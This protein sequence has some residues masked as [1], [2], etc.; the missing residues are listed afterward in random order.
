MRPR[1]YDSN[2]TFV[3]TWKQEIVNNKEKISKFELTDTRKDKA[4]YTKLLSSHP[5][6]NK[7]S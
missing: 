7:K 5:I 3:N 6:S 2:L 4:K 1:A